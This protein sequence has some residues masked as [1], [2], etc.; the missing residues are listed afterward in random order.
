M[1]I[2]WVGS[3]TPWY[4]VLAEAE[5]FYETTDRNK[6][7]QFMVVCSEIKDSEETTVRNQFVQ[8]MVQS[9]D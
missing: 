7:V 8:F 2:S 4:R 9:W 3:F 6:F 5:D 1:D